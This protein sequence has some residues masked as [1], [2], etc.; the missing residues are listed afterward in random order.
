M[1]C[2]N[3]NTTV[4][5]GMR[6]CPKCGT[7]IESISFGS[8][9]TPTYGVTGGSSQVSRTSG[10]SDVQEIQFPACGSPKV[11]KIGTNKYQCPYC[12]KVFSVSKSEPKYEQVEVPLG[13]VV[14]IHGYTQ[15]FLVDPDIKILLNGRTVGRV[16]KNGVFQI[17]VDAPCRLKFEY[18]TTSTSVDIDPTVNTDVYLSF[19]R[20]SGL[21][22]ANT[23]TDGY[24][25]SVDYDDD[26]PNIGLDIISFL[27][28]IIG[29]ILY[30][31][32]N[33]DYPQSAK[34]YLTC[35]LIG[36]AINILIFMIL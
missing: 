13:K 5:D 10:N 27:I 32:K 8:A 35:G 30:F 11:E 20:V 15:W 16:G 1:N 25:D 31:V 19:D 4:K 33:D 34:S 7:K 14:T 26:S 23:Q 21:L 24:S 6:F 18:T 17:K 22:Y 12:G 3:C 29:I 28:P 36:F 9:P 2:P